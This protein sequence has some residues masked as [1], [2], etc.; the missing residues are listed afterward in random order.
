MN[1]KKEMEW[2]LE[3]SDFFFFSEISALKGKEREKR[4]KG[5]HSLSRLN[6]P[7]L[8][9]TECMGTQPVTRS[10]LLIVVPLH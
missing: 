4:E 1:R 9:W 2:K 10:V 3:K 6:S 5:K 8:L 7:L